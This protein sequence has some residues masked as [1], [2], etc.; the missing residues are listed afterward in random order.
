MLPYLVT[1][2]VLVIIS[3]NRRATRLNTPACLGKSFV[4]DR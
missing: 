1:I 2:L 3:T 4:P